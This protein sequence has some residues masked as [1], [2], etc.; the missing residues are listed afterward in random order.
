[1]KILFCLENPSGFV[2]LKFAFVPGKFL[3]FQFLGVAI[4]HSSENLIK[5]QDL[6]IQIFIL[7]REY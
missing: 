4:S 3:G 5:K 1:M 2:L 7:S 6:P